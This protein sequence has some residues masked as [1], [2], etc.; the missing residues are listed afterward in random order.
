[1]PDG[2]VMSGRLNKLFAVPEISELDPQDFAQ[3]ADLVALA[4]RFG[5]AQN[6]RE[7]GFLSSIPKGILESMRALIYDDLS[8]PEPLAITWSWAPAY[9][10]ELSV[11]ECPGTQSKGGITVLLRSR[12]PAD[13][14]PQNL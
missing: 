12:Y 7:T 11:W 9:D 3:G 4:D 1:M 5:V 13:K 10:F 6:G 14:H 2:Q 8:R